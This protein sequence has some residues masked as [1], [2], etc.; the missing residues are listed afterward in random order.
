MDETELS[1][2]FSEFDQI[3]E[4]LTLFKTQITTIQQRVKDLE[5]NVKKQVK[6]GIAKNKNKVSRKPSGFAKPTKVTNELCYFMNQKE[7]TEL[8]RTDVTRALVSYIK[9]NKLQNKENSKIIQAD[10]KLKNLLD[11]NDGEELTYF[12][13]QK[14][15]NKHFV[16]YSK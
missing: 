1:N 4:T 2:L 11:L 8:A 5:K 12:N 15:M 10:E 13:L 9:E 6:K 3:V 14:Y 16:S 7:G